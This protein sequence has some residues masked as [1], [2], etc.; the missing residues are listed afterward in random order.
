MRAFTFL[1]LLL[2][3]LMTAQDLKIRD[4]EFVSRNKDTVQ[5]ELGTFMVPE[6][7]SNPDSREIKISFI[8]FK[9]T[10]PNPASPIVYLAGGPGGSGIQ[11]ARSARFDLFMKLREVADVIAYDQRGTGWSNSLPSFTAMKP[12][13]VTKPMA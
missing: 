2:P 4:Y 3:T 1:F 11:T 10:N 9:S 8:R 12:V 7:R 6:D 13:D 5:A